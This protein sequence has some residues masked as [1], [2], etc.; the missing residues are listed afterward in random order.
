MPKKL[1]HPNPAASP[2]VP[3]TPRRLDSWKEI[4]N[5]LKRD[6][7]TVQRWEHEKELPVRRVPGGKRH[8]VFAQ[9][10]EIEAWLKGHGG[11]S[12]LDAAAPRVVP[13]GKGVAALL[14]GLVLVALVAWHFFARPGTPV[15]FAFS[16][17]K[18]TAVDAAGRVVWTH[19]FPAEL[20]AARTRE[21]QGRYLQTADLDGDG[22][23][24]TI[25]LAAFKNPVARD[26]LFVFRSDGSLRWKY[27][28]ALTL[29]F[30]GKNYDGPW[31]I[32]RFLV[33]PKPGGAVVWVSVQHKPWWP[34]ALV[35]LG[36]E[37]HA[38]LRFVHAGWFENLASLENPQGRFIL[39]GG[40]NNEYD[41]GALAIV[42]EDDA[43]AAS[44]Q[45]PGS[46][47]A[48][49][50][51]AARG[52]AAYYVFPRSELNRIANFH[53]NSVDAILMYAQRFEVR[54]NEGTTRTN[55]RAGGVFEFSTGFEPVGI[56]F[57]DAYWD[58]HYQMEAEH[59]LNHNAA[60]CPERRRKIRRWRPGDGWLEISPTSSAAEKQ[61]H[62]NAASR[63]KTVR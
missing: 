21:E 56:S 28:P 32:N 34:A 60:D 62:F 41:A 63:A 54:T 9:V 24:E 3:L 16:E 27:V 23:N 7:R 44:P 43:L 19:S 42:R 22:E 31:G 36:A 57:T 12:N 20:Q 26:G 1:V 53:Y 29:Q 48:C 59:K 4:A 51:C 52:P 37:G 46:A 45:P 15:K 6:V 17:N 38:Q 47:F 61:P 49:T 50:N 55:M 10:E 35:Q 5:Y 39:A 58:F 14:A 30:G 18:L 8:A 13:H 2:T 11:V 33:V 40:V 25:F